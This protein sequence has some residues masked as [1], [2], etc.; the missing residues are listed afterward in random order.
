MAAALSL[1]VVVVIGLLLTRVATVAYT[2]TGM[3]LDHAR[4][5]ARSALTGTGFTT[6]EAEAVV[7]HPVRRRITMLLMLVGGAGA[8]SVLGTLL[9]SFAGVDTTAGGLRRALIIIG[10]LVAVFWVSRLDPVDRALRRAIEK[11]LIRNAD[12]EVHE[13]AALLHLRGEW[14]VAQIP[15]RRGDWLSSRPVGELGLPE[16]GAVLLGVER[17]AGTWIGTPADDLLVAPGD[18]V[19]MYGR[20]PVLEDLAVRLHGDEGHAA[21]ERFRTMHGASPVEEPLRRR[22]RA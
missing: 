13:Y 5:Q 11:F 19:V 8:V 7:N 9:L 22:H 18:A 15:V 3:S 4:F 1:T 10:S 17:E 6:A 12:L 2:L 14:G 20:R 21:S 16:E